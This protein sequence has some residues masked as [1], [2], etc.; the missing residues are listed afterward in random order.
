MCL[1]EEQ[2]AFIDCLNAIS[3]SAFVA[4]DALGIMTLLGSPVAGLLKTRSQTDCL[5]DL[6][7]APT[8][9]DKRVVSFDVS[10]D[11][12]GTKEKIRRLGQI[13]REKCWRLPT[14]AYGVVK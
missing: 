9:F 13:S 5:S 14:R 3:S 12:L 4:E 1:V 2:K 10:T 7:M 11:I 6:W 8:K